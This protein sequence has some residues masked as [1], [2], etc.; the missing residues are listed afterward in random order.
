[1][2]IE[3]QTIYDDV[4][5]CVK[6]TMLA[7]TEKSVDEINH[8]CESVKMV[9]QRASQYMDEHSEE[10]MSEEDKEKLK[11]FLS[12]SFSKKQLS[13]AEWI[14]AFSTGN[15]RITFKDC[16]V[17]VPKAILLYPSLGNLDWN[18]NYTLDELGIFV[19]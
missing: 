6:R 18:R 14:Q 2:R 5:N 9:F 15:L 13:T 17:I 12:E 1:M 3:L 19:E 10:L 8:F 11:K 4:E 7:Y 16:E